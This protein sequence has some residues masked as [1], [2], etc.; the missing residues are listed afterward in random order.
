MNKLIPFIILSALSGAPATGQSGTTRYPGAFN[1]ISVGSEIDAEL[2]ASDTARLEVNFKGV[3]ASGLLAEVED[4]TLSLRMKTGTYDKR[5]LKLK[6]YHTGLNLIESQ[7]RANVWST[8][9]IPV[10]ELTLNLNN[11]G[12]MRLKVDCGRLS[13]ELIQ[14][15]ILII[16]GTAD[17]LDLKVSSGATF[18]GYNLMVKEA[19][20]LSNSAGKAKINVSDVLKAKAVSGGFIGYMGEPGVLE[21]RARMKG[22]IRKAYPEE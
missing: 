1:K 3:D 4:S 18:S 20:V 8:G 9:T 6:V 12:S 16:E 2:V 5:D 7:G 19:D 10:Q 17:T 14:G 13:S 11:G 15:S 21:T 22:E